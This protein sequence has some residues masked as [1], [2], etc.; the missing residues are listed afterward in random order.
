M[1]YDHN[2]EKQKRNHK[3]QVSNRNEWF[4]ISSQD[5]K[6]WELR[7]KLLIRWIKKQAGLSNG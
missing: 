7:Q 5:D 4:L 6:Y 3:I 1:Q 2:V